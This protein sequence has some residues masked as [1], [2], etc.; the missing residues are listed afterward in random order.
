ME[1]LLT[2]QQVAE[3]LALSRSTVY[4]LMERGDLRYAKIGRSRR[5]PSAEVDR[6]IRDSL[7]GGRDVV[8]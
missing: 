8:A 1:K 6:L 3:L 7:I 2:V 5:I 4:N